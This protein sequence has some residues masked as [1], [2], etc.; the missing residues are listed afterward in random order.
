MAWAGASSKGVTTSL[1]TVM[2]SAGKVTAPERPLL[3]NPLARL[4]TIFAP[5]RHRKLL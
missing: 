3:C 2:V 1:L 5:E 4:D